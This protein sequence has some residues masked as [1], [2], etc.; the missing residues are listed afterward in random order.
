MSQTENGCPV[1][2]SDDEPCGRPIF[3]AREGMDASPVCRMHSK[4]PYKGA[5]KF[6]EEIDTILKGKSK[7]HRPKEKFDFQG[8]VFLTLLFT[9]KT[10]EKPVN[11][12]GIEVILKADFEEAHFNKNADFSGAIFREDARFMSVTFHED[13]EFSEAHFQRNAN[14]GKTTFV[15]EGIFSATTFDGDTYFTDA[16]FDRIAYFQSARFRS[17]ADFWKA[18]FRLEAL[19]IRTAFHVEDDGSC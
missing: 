5:S 10:F 8:F 17:R 9:K 18:T 6:E 16:K 19:F 2:M 1:E 7:H 14:F 4:D 12:K 3:S 11:L 13:A 15:G